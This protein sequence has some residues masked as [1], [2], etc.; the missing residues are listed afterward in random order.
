MARVVDFEDAAQE[1]T[2]WPTTP[3][4]GVCQLLKRLGLKPSSI[5]RWEINEAFAMVVTA[6]V[7]L[8]GKEFDETVDMAKV[9]VAGGAVTMGH[10]FGMSG[11]R[12][13]NHLAL[14]LQPG[15]LGIATLC[16]GGGGASTI[17]LEGV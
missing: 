3:A 2:E 8:I 9:N 14:N 12:I 16:N 10:P 7:A 4:L 5:D 13:T 11:A 17:L 15:Q 6:N 1:P